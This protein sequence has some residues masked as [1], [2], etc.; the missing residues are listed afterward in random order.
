LCTLKLKQSTTTTTK[1][2]KTT[3]EQEEGSSH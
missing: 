3:I 2:I 1:Q